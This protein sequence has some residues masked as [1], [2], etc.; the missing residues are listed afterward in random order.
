MAHFAQIDTSE[1]KADHGHPVLSVIVVANEDCLDG[2]GNESEAVGIAFCKSLF[3][4]DTD[5]VQT[6]YNLNMR[7]EF[8]NKGMY[9]DATDD[10]FK[11]ECPVKGW[12][13]K[14]DADGRLMWHWPHEPPEDA[15]NGQPYDWDED[16]LDWVARERAELTPP[17]PSWTIVD[18]VPTPPTPAP[19]D[20]GPDKQYHWDEENQTW[21]LP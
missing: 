8:A 12:V 9:Y 17:Y 1:T 21:V 3:G 7:G 13:W 15:N 11:G 18:T 20:A 19:A 16:T 2:D 5:W 4:A 6:S 10:I 14:A